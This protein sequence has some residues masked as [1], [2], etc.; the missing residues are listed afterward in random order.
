M[1]VS[2]SNT[3]AGEKLRLTRLLWWES[4]P[5][6]REEGKK[7]KSEAFENSDAVLFINGV[8]HIDA[9]FPL[10]PSPSSTCL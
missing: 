7:K 4:R 1:S 10:N 9:A 5:I 3:S 2:I 8:Q 6:R